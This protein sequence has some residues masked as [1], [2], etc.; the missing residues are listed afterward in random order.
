MLKKIITIA[1]LSIVVFT[2]KAQVE[3]FVLNGN[4]TEIAKRE[5]WVDSVYNQMSLEQRVGQLFIFTIA[6]QMNK[7]NQAQLKK[8]VQDYHVGGLLFSGGEVANQVKLT[9]MA[10]EW[11]ETPL[12]I[13]FDG[14]WGL[15]MRLKNTPKFPRN[16]VLGSITDETLLYAYG[17]EMGRECRE[18][19]V[20][21]NFAPVGDVNVNP[22]NPVINTRS[23]GENPQ[24]VANK[25]IAYSKGLESQ[26][27]LSVTKHF[28]GH[29][30]TN[31]DSHKALP[32]LPFDRARLDS[33][34]LYPF[35]A[36]IEAKLGGVMVGH[37]DVPTLGT[38]SGEPSSLSYSVVQKTL[39]DSLGFTGLVFTD[40]LAMKGAGSHGG[41]CL[42]A[43]QAG[44]D[45]LLTPPQIKRELNLV[46]EAVKKGV[47]QERII[48][49]KC[50]KILTYKYALGLDK[51]QRIQLSGLDQRINTPEAKELIKQIELSAITLIKNVGA[52]LP[53]HPSIKKVALV[54]SGS[55]DEYNTLSN[56]LASEYTVDK[57]AIDPSL[58]VAS[59]NS[60]L[61]KLEKY[62]RVF[63]CLSDKNLERYDTYFEVLQTNRPLSFIFFTGGQ[64]LRKMEKSIKNAE[65]AILAHANDTHIQEGVSDV[66][67]G[68]RIASGRLAVSIGVTYPAGT[69]VLKVE[70]EI[71]GDTKYLAEDLGFIPSVLEQIDS[72]MLESI[73]EGAFTG[74]QVAVLKDGHFAYH[75]SFGTYTGDGSHTVNNDNFF[76]LASLSKTTGTLLA[77]MKL[78][79]SG[80]LN[81]SDRIS[82]FIPELKSTDKQNITIQELLF[83]E[84][85]MPAGL[86]VYDEIIDKKS[87]VGS[88]YKNKKDAKHTVRLG[89]RLWANPNYKFEKGLVS[90]VKT[91]KHTLQVADNL[92]FDSSIKDRMMEVI[93]D[94]SLLSKKYRYSCLG[95]ILLQRAVENISGMKMDEF[96]EQNFYEPMKLEIM[97][98]PLTKINKE[99]IIPSND[100]RF[101]RK[102]VLQGYVHDET[103]AL[104]GGV[105]G[106]AGLFGRSEDV[107]RVY[108]ML[109][110]GGVYQGKRY[111][112][113]STCKLFTTKKSKIS[114][115]GLGFDKPNS[116]KGQSSPCSESTP[117]ET[118]GHTG[119]TGTCAWADPVHNLVYVFLSNRIY[120]SVWP[121]K[122]S[123]LEVREKV[124]EII[125][126]S[127]KEEI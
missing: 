69:G 26:D 61:N 8:V 63:V 96:L 49:E 47:L 34:E 16:M 104:L 89:S 75:K 77:I 59:R 38:K 102:E 93:M 67:R 99:Q 17:K 114:R 40:A 25:V 19:G 76:D 65:A 29:G 13:T 23:F 108:Q 124:Q 66:L 78:Y 81:L 50:K 54:Y 94:K 7:Q 84:S 85:G 14:E 90:S 115:R 109:L 125:Y 126:Q 44:N 121:N 71:E 27:V 5:A 73:Q 1:L 57:I 62:D 24:N 58:S 4:P 87:F 103:A 74:A 80:K 88:L 55:A 56:S 53:L 98:N 86:S 11:A 3:P 123:S 22:N 52:T 105:S 64:N 10:Q 36:L 106:N 30:D 21:V 28:P 119:F 6:P 18:M 60:L 111:L 68:T 39:K 2:G 45:M 92:W 91:D 46:V 35:K 72:I 100:D 41:V 82:D 43:I 116:I 107:A 113:E 33:V 32:I 83:H 127:L 120:P 15:A 110:D 20:H 31:V 117:L 97:Y 101:F 70:E 95:F 112:G 48:E 9:N 42:K 51:P 12:M 118:F 37:L 122:L 79:D